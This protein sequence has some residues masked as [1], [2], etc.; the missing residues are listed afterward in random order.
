MKV[1]YAELNCVTCSLSTANAVP[2]ES[3]YVFNFVMNV[4]EQVSAC[5]D[6]DG[7]MVVEL[8]FNEGKL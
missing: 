2:D 8:L 1:Q 4:K 6:A 3:D 5:D 7:G